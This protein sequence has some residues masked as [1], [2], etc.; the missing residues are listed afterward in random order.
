MSSLQLI[1]TP[2]TSTWGLYSTKKDAP[3]L[4]GVKMCVHYQRKPAAWYAV[5]KKSHQAFETWKS[6][7]ITGPELVASP[8]GELQQFTL[9][10]APERCGLNITFTFALPKEHPLLL[11]KVDLQN[12]GK[13]PIWI[14][15]IEMLKA[16]FFPKKTRLPEPGP[17]TLHKN[18]IPNRQG[19]IRPHPS[20]GEMAF[21]SNGW[22][23]W[24][25]TG[26]Y[27]AKDR[28]QQTRLD[29]LTVPMWY[30]AGTPRPKKAGYFVSDMFGVLGDRQH[31]TGIL[32][33]YLSQKEH[34]GSLKVRIDDPFYPALHMWANGDHARLGPGASMTTDWAVVQF[35]DIDA[36]DP[37]APYLNAVAREN[38]I[39]HSPAVPNS[40]PLTADA[41]VGWCSWY[42]YFQ[43]ITA[44]DVRKNLQTAQKI[45][46]EI[47]LNLI[48]IDDGYQER[49]GD[50]LTFSA[51]FPKGVQPLAD[52]IKEAGFTPGLWVAPFIIHPK[53]KLA[54]NHRNW[55][56]RN[57]WRLPVNAG[58]VWNT[59]T[60]ALDLTYPPALEYVKE[61]LHTAVNTWGFSYLKLD[62]LYA[63]ALN[64]KYH[65]STKTRAQVLRQS[66]EAIRESV[67][68]ETTLLGCGAPLGPAL[69]LVDAM[70]IGADVAP[71]WYPSFGG[72]S[73]IFKSETNMPSVRNA[74]QNII[75]R[76]P[77]HN[78]W[79]IN[80]PDCLLLRPN[81]KLTLNEVRA[82]ATGIAFSGGLALLSDNL[83]AIPEERL[84]IA[85]AILPPIGQ[86]PRVLG[87]FDEQTPSLL[88][89]DLENETGEWS[90]IAVFNWDIP[91]ETPRRGSAT[92]DLE[93]E[94]LGFNA[95]QAFYVSPF[96][97]GEPALVS[98]EELTLNAVPAHGVKVI[99]LRPF[100]NGS[101]QYVGS[102]LHIA[103]GLEV[104]Q[105]SASP[106]TLQARLERPGHAQ[107]EIILSLPAPPQYLS[108]NKKE[109]PWRKAEGNLYRFQVDFYET[110]ELRLGC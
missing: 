82:L 78:R 16:G 58:F 60:R 40:N 32:S 88:R 54:R 44:D 105:W 72:L 50:W 102:D 20:P 42:D 45:K 75:T 90:L 53:S 101:I 38:D 81:T 51:G 66:L 14:D 35:V 67:G 27:G 9:A 24:S 64:G 10:M 97:D 74:L 62:F 56:L 95:G 73:A 30:N 94:R 52:E 108:L 21:Y 61:V 23:S 79:W 8:H 68:E 89:L 4:D 96:W 80:D 106:Q 34:F 104:A 84:R 65:D 91:V 43:D 25:H 110:G 69:G 77:L 41:S 5:R 33:G 100:V 17:I 76:A 63:A 70:R 109:I 48:Q 93:M 26:S 3:Y 103:Q 18:I 86:R 29:F 99:A 83:A 98:G 19:V 1:L 92:I 28:Y 107:G 7:E 39:P 31:R 22:Q 59:F 11:W 15:K 85:Q 47:P 37:L 55:L 36:P 71:D 49:I 46:N 87:W 2:K 6:P 13:R 12:E 57:R